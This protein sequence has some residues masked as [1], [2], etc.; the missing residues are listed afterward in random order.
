MP[1][2][3]K[4]FDKEFRNKKWKKYKK[5]NYLNGSN[6]NVEILKKYNRK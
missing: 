6:N 5:W 4:C 1:N 2:G 3:R